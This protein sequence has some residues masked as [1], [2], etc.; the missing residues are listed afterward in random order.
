MGTT[1]RWAFA[2]VVFSWSG[3]AD[4]CTICVATPTRTAADH[5]IAA[6]VVALAREDATSPFKFRILELLKGT[7][8]DDY[9]YLSLDPS[10]Q[11]RRAAQR[12][13]GVVLVRVGTSTWK[14][15]GHADSAFEHMVRQLLEFAPCWRSGE[16]CR[17]SRLEFFAPLLAHDIPQLHR[18]A[19][20]EIGRAPYASIKAHSGDWPAERIRQLLRDPA[21][22]KR[23]PL[24][25]LMLAHNGDEADHRFIED[26]FRSHARQSLS[27]HLSAWATAYI[28]I[29]GDE[30][31]STIEELY[32]H[33]RERNRTELAE[34]VRALSEHGSNGR[35]D[36]R[37]DIAR[38][39]GVLIR[40][41]PG[42][43][44]V[45]AADLTRWGRWELAGDLAE[46]LEE[47]SPD[48]LTAYA[49][50]TYLARASSVQL[51]AE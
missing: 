18:L 17:P 42:L 28:E 40:Q 5:V 46:L 34:I 24:A 37:A 8:Q 31:V 44:G 19:Y 7:V 25:I 13:Q 32:F 21:Q 48:P 2:L 43:A 15:V 16:E 33:N 47:R 30:G 3:L 9:V 20:L 14:N 6:E 45:V 26:T 4:A 22:A 39:Y 51:S 12:E 41:Y 50:K 29:R 1:I 35:V 36:L 27:A 23:Y 11:P 10:A 49:I 38:S